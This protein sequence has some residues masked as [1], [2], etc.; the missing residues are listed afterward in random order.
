MRIK[1]S[2]A[3]DRIVVKIENGGEIEISFNAADGEGEPSHCRIF[4]NG[5]Q[6]TSHETTKM[7]KME[8]WEVPLPRGIGETK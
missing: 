7:G 8:F 4:Q 5:R 6:V 1:V 3:S 2:Q